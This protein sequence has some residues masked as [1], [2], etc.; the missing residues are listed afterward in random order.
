M[1]SSSKD[2][3][4][5]TRAPL[6]SFAA[7]IKGLAGMRPTVKPGLRELVIG[8]FGCFIL[9]NK[10]DFQW[11]LK[12]SEHTQA[13][14]LKI[15]KKRKFEI[16][17]SSYFQPFM[18]LFCQ[19]GC[20]FLLDMMALWSKATLRGNNLKEKSSIIHLFLDS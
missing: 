9:N 17:F 7:P 2:F 18:A 12:I 13:Q 16:F 15:I 5:K 1:H 6:A 4:L 3:S 10:M 20:L 19:T 11:P 14:H 8:L